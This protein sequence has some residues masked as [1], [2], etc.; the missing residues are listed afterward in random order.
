M[1]KSSY[2]EIW[3]YV[4]LQWHFFFVKA[5][6][7]KRY[8]FSVILVLSFLTTTERLRYFGFIVLS[9]IYARP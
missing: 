3:T 7:F 1:V 5:L 9:L 4:F 8:L 6:S 2:F